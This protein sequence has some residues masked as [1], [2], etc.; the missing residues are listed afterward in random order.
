MSLAREKNYEFFEKF[1]AIDR[2]VKSQPIITDGEAQIMTQDEDGFAVWMISKEP[3]K[4]AFLVV[5]NYQ[6]PTEF[7]TVNENGE[8]RQEWKKGQ[9]VFNK[10]IKL[11]GDFTVLSEYVIK[12][13]RYS[14]QYFENPKTELSFEELKPSEFRIFAM[15]K[16]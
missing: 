15:Q 13:K 8:S 9:S 6:Y 1:D 16:M 12:D 5:S 3:L 14:P 10:E 11:P 7:V 2:F 4:K